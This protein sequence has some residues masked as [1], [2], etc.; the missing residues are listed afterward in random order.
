[1]HRLSKDS[2]SPVGDAAEIPDDVRIFRK[3]T[4][5]FPIPSG[6]VEFDQVFA[7][8]REW[9]SCAESRQDGWKVRDLGGGLMLA[10]R[11]IC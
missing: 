11:L 8:R 7:T 9:E 10:Q 1:M 5:V 2:S 4:T 6:P 3:A